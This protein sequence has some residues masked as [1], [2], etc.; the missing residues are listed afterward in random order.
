M[1][2]TLL[3]YLIALCVMAAVACLFT[4]LIARPSDFIKVELLL[5]LF[6]VILLFIK[7]II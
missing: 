3:F 7:S 2:E 1:I 5:I 4:L 6:I